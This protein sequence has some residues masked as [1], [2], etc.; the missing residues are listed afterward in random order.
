MMKHEELPDL[1]GDG[2]SRS[3]GL[4]YNY[5]V[6]LYDLLPYQMTDGTSMFYKREFPNFEDEIYYLLECA[7]LQNEEP[8]IIIDECRKLIDARNKDILDN[9]GTRTDPYECFISSDELD[10]SVDTDERNDDE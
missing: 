3:K 1:M 6:Q 4:Q 8:D 9:F 2:F 5:Q 10:Y 7:T